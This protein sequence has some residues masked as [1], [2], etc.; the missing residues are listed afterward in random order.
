MLSYEADLQ[1]MVEPQRSIADLL[2]CSVDSEIDLHLP[3]FED[4][5]RPA[6]LT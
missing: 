2:A 1:K 3:R 6:D 4:K 5:A